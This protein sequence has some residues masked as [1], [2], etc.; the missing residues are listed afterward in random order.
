MFPVLNW[1]LDDLGVHVLKLNRHFSEYGPAQLWQLF[2]SCHEIR[3]CESHYEGQIF[4]FRYKMISY[5]VKAF[6]F[7]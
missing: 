2:V 6:R 7:V 4:N 3:S 1:F 5:L